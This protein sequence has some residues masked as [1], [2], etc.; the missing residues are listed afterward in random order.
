MPYKKYPVSRPRRL[1]RTRSMR[2][3][4]AEVQLTPKD[5]IY[6][7]FVVHGLSIKEEIPAMPDQFHWSI[8]KLDEIIN[9][10]VSSGISGIM[11]FGIPKHKDKYGTE[12]SNPDGIVQKAIKKIRHIAPDL[13]ISTDVCLCGY[14]DSGHCGIVKK[15]VV[16][17]DETLV[18]LEKIALSHAEAGADIVAPS[19][20][21]DGAIQA[22]RKS[23]DSKGFNCVSIMSYAVKYASAYY[24]PFRT[25]CNSSLTGD[26]K[27]YQM[28]FHNKKEA[29]KEMVLDEQEGAD[30]I[31]IKPA[32]AYLDII[33]DI[34]RATTLPVAAYHVSGEY[35]MIKAAAERNW[36]DENKVFYETL[37]AIKRSGANIIISYAALNIA[38]Q[39]S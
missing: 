31:I 21:M 27:T 12:S 1:R 20:M 23:L 17:N 32:T 15:D 18:V 24:G 19:G 13:L 2:K 7:I 8:D 22:I 10:V 28:D 30:F 37:T 11:I 33:S 34:S 29:I 6:P 5:F 4:I 26:R 9:D 36:L 3:M 16:C 38:K 39:L 35:A 25:A 14:T